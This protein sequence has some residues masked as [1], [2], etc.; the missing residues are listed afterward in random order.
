MVAG[1]LSVYVY[2]T[3]SAGDQNTKEQAFAAMHSKMGINI[4]LG[5][6]PPD[7]SGRTT[8]I[9]WGRADPGY[10]AEGVLGVGWRKGSGGPGKS[11][12]MPSN[13]EPCYSAN[14][15]CTFHD[16]TVKN[17]TDTQLVSSSDIEGFAI[18]TF[19]GGIKP[20]R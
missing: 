18:A 14:S 19:N 1:G 15:S 3:G 12:N 10:G 7:W 6:T 16:Y 9:P 11:Y 4:P 20:G 5:V 8:G 2:L 17:C 13:S